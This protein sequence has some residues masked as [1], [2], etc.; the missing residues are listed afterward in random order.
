[1][2]RGERR[3][4]VYGYVK[5]YIEENGYA[6]KLE[7]ISAAVGVSIQ[8][9]AYQIYKLQKLGLVYHPVGKSRGIRL[10]DTPEWKKKMLVRFTN[11][12]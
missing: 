7:E 4:M 2:R 1:M 10:V 5:K 9:V 11:T 12:N 3:E 8:S 6:P